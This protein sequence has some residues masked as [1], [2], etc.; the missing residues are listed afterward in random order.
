MSLL[1]WFEEIREELEENN[2]KKVVLVAGASSSGKSYCS[3]KLKQ[4]FEMKGKRV[5]VIPADMYYKGMAKIVV[6]N[7][8]LKNEEFRGL[9]SQIDD[10]AQDMISVNG[11][12]PYGEKFTEENV[13]KIE[14]LWK[15]KLLGYSLS[16]FMDKVIYQYKNINYDEPFDINFKQLSK[17]I[18]NIMQGK[19]IIV[20]KYSF[21]NSE[22]EINEKNTLNVN[23]YDCFIIEGLYTLRDELLNNINASKV[24]TTAINCDVKT[25]LLRRFY[26]DIKTDR[27]SFTPEQTI[28]SFITNVMPN[29][30]EHIFPTL[31][32]AN[33]NYYSKLSDIEI[34]SKDK[35]VQTKYSISPE[36]LQKLRSEG[37]LITSIKQKDYFLED[38]THINPETLTLRLREEKGL[39]T[40]LSIK[41]D[42]EVLRERAIEEYNLTKCL[43]KE[44]RDTTTLLERF[45]KSGYNISNI[46]EKNREIYVY[47]DV[48]LK[49]DIIKGIGTFV[50][51]DGEKNTA[52][53]ELKEELQIKGGRTDSYYEILKQ[54]LSKK[55]NVE[56][57]LKFRLRGVNEEDLKQFTRQ[58]INQYYLDLENG[59]LHNLINII[60]KDKL[61]FEPSEARVRIINERDSYLTLKNNE[62]NNR[63]ECELKVS[64]NYAHELLEYKDKFIE[65]NRY[66]ILKEKDKLVEIDFYKNRNLCIMEIEYDNRLNS[67]E[68]IFNFAR[69]IIPE[70]VDLEDVTY[71]KS[72]KN[73]NLAEKVEDVEM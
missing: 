61:S 66:R 65:K 64:P 70:Q 60:L 46:I 56:S 62:L 54:E 13:Q 14:N 26:R 40:K 7:A 19:N 1:K 73:I 52:I 33:I 59:G 31:S 55:A 21:Y 22:S 3:D 17:D 10:I 8:V 23:Q 9:E 48:V 42:T 67:E 27:C 69:K 49:L 41:M 34:K 63:Q 47:N 5:A 11:Q 50:E 24:V 35:S 51:L 43:S 45:K 28:I 20:P 25:L 29:Y 68:Q 18:N 36:M 44:N 32:K 71:D 53:T 12:L 4:Y 39:A 16:N 2:D 38:T 72:Y 15:S 58:E 6:G 30:Y 37:K 57:E